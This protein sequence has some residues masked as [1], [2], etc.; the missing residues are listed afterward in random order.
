MPTRVEAVSRN[1]IGNVI[2]KNVKSLFSKI[3]FR[4]MSTTTGQFLPLFRQRD[5][6]KY[7]FKWNGL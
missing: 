2:F 3:I 6:R 7:F 1:C 5:L 4:K